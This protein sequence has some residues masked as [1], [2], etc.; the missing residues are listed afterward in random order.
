MPALRP[1]RRLSCQPHVPD[2]GHR[3]ALP[4]YP[5]SMDVI[6]TLA[7]KVFSRGSPFVLLAW[8][9]WELLKDRIIS[10]TNS[11]IDSWIGEAAG[12]FILAFLSSPYAVP[13]TLAVL[14]FGWMA[15]AW[16]RDGR[17]GS[18]SSRRS[19][20]APARSAKPVASAPTPVRP[21]PSPVPPSA[22]PDKPPRPPLTP[23]EI[24]TRLKVIDEAIVFVRDRMEQTVKDGPRLAGNWWNG[25]ADK[26]NNPNYRGELLAFRDKIKQDLDDLEAFR[27][28]NAFF[29]PVVIA[30]QPAY[31]DKVL[32]PCDGM[33]VAFQYIEQM[34]TPKVG[35]EGP[36]FFMKSYN[37]DFKQAIQTFGGW[38]TS[39][40]NQLMDLRRELAP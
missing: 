3:R 7:I 11:L 21:P 24:E 29:Q 14:I 39:A 2:L 33:L 19:A 36:N 26:T 13:A 22:P 34:W 6:R 10:G 38:R 16:Q 40:L 30:V 37:D 4:C 15:I 31:W 18:S 23:Y 8:F 27:T 32:R 28:K 5:R 25:L 20:L 1:L 9:G 17:P 12:R 35:P